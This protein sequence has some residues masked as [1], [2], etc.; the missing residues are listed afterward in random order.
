[1]DLSWLWGGNGQIDPT[2]IQPAQFGKSR[3]F[4]S[5][6]DLD[7]ARKND[8]FRYTGEYTPNTFQV[9]NQEV[10]GGTDLIR[11]A[12]QMGAL[13]EPEDQ[14]LRDTL[15]RNQLAARRSGIVSLAAN[16]PN[17][18]VVGAK[19]FTYEGFAGKTLIDP[20]RQDPMFSFFGRE[21][22]VDPS[23]PT[24]EAAHRGMFKVVDEIMN[25]PNTEQSSEL[26]EYLAN[27]HNQELAVRA[28]MHDLYDDVEQDR[29]P[30]KYRKFLESGDVDKAREMN[31]LA[32][33]IAQ[34]M[35]QR[36]KPGGPW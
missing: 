23:T 36:R 33:T 3:P 21:N 18:Q 31:Q 28:L 19:D 1:M 4:P 7:F 17:D 12:T 22:D 20:K 16:D 2:E 24:H 34:K 8:A 26:R 13:G 10:D 29:M 32:E 25:M 6:E 35:I 9:S 14:T 27:P 5:Q 15:A 11:I 30:E